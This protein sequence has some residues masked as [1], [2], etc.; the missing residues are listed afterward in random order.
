VTEID[1]QDDDSGGRPASQRH[2]RQNK[3]HHRNQAPQVKRPALT[4]SFLRDHENPG[5]LP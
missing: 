4:G 3:T 2:A 5:D 1:T